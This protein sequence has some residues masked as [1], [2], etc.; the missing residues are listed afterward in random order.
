MYDQQP[1]DEPKIF[2]RLAIKH[3]CL[4]VI[5]GWKGSLM[6]NTQT[7]A[8]TYTLNFTCGVFL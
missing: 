2:N 6:Y 1:K 3:F 4:N 7:Y 8:H 5:L